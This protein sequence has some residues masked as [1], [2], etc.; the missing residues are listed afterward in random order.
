MAPFKEILCHMEASHLMLNENKLPGFSMMQVFTERCLRADFHFSLNVNITGV[1][2]MNK[3]FI[4]NETSY[5]EQQ[6]IDSIL[7][8]I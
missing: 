5:F 6:W 4:R 7:L 2:F 3:Q 1:S 8:G